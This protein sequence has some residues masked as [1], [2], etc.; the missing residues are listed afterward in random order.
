MNSEKWQRYINN[1]CD[2]E[3]R[4]EIALWLQHLPA[5]ELDK[6]MEQGWRDDAPAMPEDVDQRVWM[7]LSQKISGKN[8][9]SYY[10]LP[11]WVWMAAA[12]IVLLTGISIWLMQVR[13]PSPAAGLPD[14]AYRD[15]RNQSAVVEKATLPD[16]SQVWLTPQSVLRIGADFNQKERKVRLEGEGYFEVARNP[17]RPFSVT[18]GNLQT[19]VLGTHFN[20]ESYAG[21][22]TAIVT[23]TEGSIKVD[24]TDSSILLTPG[25]RLTYQK[26]KKIFRTD[27]NPKGE[28][29]LWK[30]GALILDDLAVSDAFR[31]IAVR[32]GKKIIFS[33]AA[34]SGRR[35]TGHYTHATLE[36]VLANMGYVQGF[37]YQVKGDS[38]L[39]QSR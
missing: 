9:P 17:G 37:R 28:E 5:E 8:M 15:I 4:K 27:R 3:E 13:K 35:F 36:T 6:I 38:V 20:I 25:T 26:A 12:C 23:L 39:I 7:G 10:R 32:F 16:G 11:G 1:Q 19:R 29:E 18:A 21:E 30:S 24:G 14:L 22:S 31:R 33:E 2:P 34:F